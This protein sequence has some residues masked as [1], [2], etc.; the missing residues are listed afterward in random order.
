MG[1]FL[2]LF[3]GIVQGASQ[4]VAF[5]RQ[6]KERKDLLALQQQRIKLEEREQELRVNQL[7][8]V[9]TGQK[10]LAE[11]LETQGAVAAGPPAGSPL[12]IQPNPPEVQA[13]ALPFGLA[14]AFVRAGGVPQAQQ[15]LQQAKIFGPAAP[16]G[17][18]L[19]ELLGLT[20][21]PGF[22]RQ[23]EAEPGKPPRLTLREQPPPP[24]RQLLSPEEFAQQVALARAKKE[25]VP[26]P[27]EVMEQQMQL[28]TAKIATEVGARLEAQFVAREDLPL[29]EKASFWMDPETFEIAHPNDTLR[30]VKDRKL[31]P[32][33]EGVRNTL[34]SAR[35][36]LVQINQY[37]RLIPKLLVKR[38][39]NTA[40][41][42]AKVQA[43]ALKIRAQAKA[44]DPDARLL[45]ALQGAI[46]VFARG[47]SADS[48]VSDAER[49][50]LLAMTLSTND[51]QESAQLVLDQADEVFRN[52]IK[53]HLG[54]LPASLQRPSTE[55]QPS[56]G[57]GEGQATPQQLSS[58]AHLGRLFRAGQLPRMQAIRRLMEQADLTEVEASAVVAGWEKGLSQRLRR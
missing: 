10:S 28:A 39:G 52:V 36:A 26:L 2:P 5:G 47:T 54:R 14:A 31:V 18:S 17:P 7:Q 43:N 34:G 53:G 13:Q 46:T 23:I 55:R 16:E 56:A 21:P 6:L 27:P 33:T 15:I 3:S 22:T 50:F 1:D 25:P 51:T 45:T 19:E 24:P 9:L 20:V 4:G 37:R 32:V 42:L 49:R 8:E 41:D 44:G 12:T 58:A 30:S 29:N 38:T 11:F 35:A 48:R 57:P 40:L